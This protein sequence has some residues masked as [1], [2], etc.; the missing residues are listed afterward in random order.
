MLIISQQS[1]PNTENLGTQAQPYDAGRNGPLC[2]QTLIATQEVAS[3]INM[4]E[5]QTSI[6]I[7]V[8]KMIPVGVLSRDDYQEED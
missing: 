3:A 8:E 6:E 4:I 1:Q 2:P 5:I 7:L